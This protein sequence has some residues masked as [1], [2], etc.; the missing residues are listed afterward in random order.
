M[1]LRDPRPKSAS[2]TGS[3]GYPNIYAVT[4]Y[5]GGKLI[6][7]DKG[8]NVIASVHA[9]DGVR[10]PAIIVASSPHKVGSEQTPWQDV[11]DIDNGHIRYYGDNRR[12][13]IDPDATHGNQALK[14]ALDQHLSPLE[15]VRRT[16]VPLVF[17]RRVSREGKQKGYPQFEGFGIVR[18]C[19]RVT[20][21]D[22]H[23]KPFANYVFE[24]LVMS[25]AEENELFDWDWINGRRN[26]AL[27][28]S[29]TLAAAPIAWR[30]WVKNGELAISAVRRSVVKRHIVPHASQQPK[31]GSHGDHILAAVRKYYVG[32][33]Y[34][35]E[36]VAAWVTERLLSQSGGMYRHYGV[37]RSSG[38]RGFDFVGRLDLGVGFGGVK[39][40][41][42]GQAKCEAPKTAT[43][44]LD[45]A[46]TVARLRRG[47]IGSYVTTGY[48]SLQTQAEILQDRYPI[49][50]IHGLLIGEELEKRMLE[51]GTNDLASILMEIEGTHGALTE[52]SDPDQVLF[53]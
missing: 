35:F 37:T 15:S 38:D 19:R 26:P 10:V 47:W 17:F 16:S 34:R 12:V 9:V 40:I 13:G 22:A 52:V 20:Q 39:L 29:D 30:R 53:Q 3:N 49:L 41:V 7:F 14:R 24:F 5:A 36:A 25:L 4:A 33:E 27:T 21:L 32:K 48:F 31:S 2:D 46:R 44:G 6:P 1:V 23:G 51:R 43:S 8:I 28:A 42:L 50:L 45:V 18:T 11:F